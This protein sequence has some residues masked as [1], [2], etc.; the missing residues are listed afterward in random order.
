MNLRFTI[1]DLRAAF[2]NE[3]G[4]NTIA[5]RKSYIANCKFGDLRAALE[6]ERGVNTIAA[7]KSYIVNR[8]FAE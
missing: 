2:Q 6:N 4:G 8:K 5:A 1:Y 7:R 3:R